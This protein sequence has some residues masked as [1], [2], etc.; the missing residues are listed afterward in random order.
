MKNIRCF[1][2]NWKNRITSI[3]CVIA[4]A[5]SLVSCGQTEESKDTLAQTPSGTQAVTQTPEPFRGGTLNVA[6]PAGLTSANPLDVTSVEWLSFLGLIYESPVTID[7]T[8]K[9]QPCLAE[10]WSFDEGTMTWTFNI[11]KGAKWQGKDTELSADD[12]VYTLDCLKNGSTHTESIYKSV[13][14]NIDS[15][16]A[17]ANTLQIKVKSKGAVFL[18]SMIFPVLA[19]QYGTSDTAVPV[20]TGPYK[21]K[22][23]NL[24][25]KIELTANENWWKDQPY[26]TNI[27]G[28]CIQDNATVLKSYEGG[29]LNLA[30]TANLS[31]NQ[32]K[33]TGIT[34][35]K[36]ILTNYYDCLIPNFSRQ[37][38][39]NKNIRKA[40]SFAI[41]R[42]EITSR[43]YLGHAV[44]ADMP[45]ISGDYLYNLRNE[46]YD[47]NKN[48]AMDLLEQAGYIDR[49][50][51]SYV[52]NTSMKH[53]TL[54]L[55]V[56][57][58]GE[59]Q[60]YKEVALL[61]QQ[62]LKDVGIEI[63][64]VEK[65][66]A[67]YLTSLSSGDF[68]LVIAGFYLSQKPDWAYMLANGAAGNYGKYS[69]AEISSYLQAVKTADE[70]ELADASAALQKFFLDELP[71]IGLYF[72]T[73][74]LIYNANI[75]RIAGIKDPNIFQ[76]IPQWYLGKS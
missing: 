53:L 2:K 25:G 50:N 5:A 60:S 71:N 15:Y 7:S 46:S 61:I 18:Y 20:G 45:T 48:K 26:I 58:G 13:L 37:L 51:D 42:S 8:G 43:V 73:K 39:A 14:D 40:I 22:S 44:A 66:E 34:D 28:N 27:T 68:D 30:Y 62:Q 10:N 6:I 59:H 12:I 16:S 65:N 31:A 21:V 35:T 11:R 38:T 1:I 29:T 76:T 63:N 67:D 69:N 74:T 70:K 36:E 32:Y 56:S 75:T 41:D 47:Y 9:V 64:I 33:Q 24:T 55:L 57:S 49:D 19:R 23:F 4:I 72:K 52:D 17:D 54:N 3:C